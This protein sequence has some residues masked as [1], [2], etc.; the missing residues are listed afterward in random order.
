[1]VYPDPLKQFR[2]QVEKIQ[3]IVRQPL[4]LVERV[5]AERRAVQQLMA[6]VVENPFTRMARETR[7]W[8]DE[9]ERRRWSFLVDQTPP[10]PPAAAE[11]DEDDQDDEGDDDRPWPGQ[12]L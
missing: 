10:E 1:M 5:M 3:A 8:L 6:S 7:E 2:E 11:D 4:E 12:Y 9:L